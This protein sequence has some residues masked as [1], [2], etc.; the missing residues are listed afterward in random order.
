MYSRGQEAESVKLP[1][2]E[3]GAAYRG[4]V[5]GIKKEPLL[6]HTHGTE[7]RGPGVENRFLPFRL[8][9]MVMDR[10]VLLLSAPRS[11]STNVN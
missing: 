9:N 2:V 11:K 7:R 10:P 1:G 8:G 6:A 3:I 5:T 4:K